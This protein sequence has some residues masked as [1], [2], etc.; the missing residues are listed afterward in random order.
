[1]K[2]ETQN[3]FHHCVNT[4]FCVEHRTSSI[5]ISI[6]LGTLI[7]YLS[8]QESDNLFSKLKLQLI[9]T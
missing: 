2:Y 6:S 7:R 1:M 8:K 4:I 5:L 3:D 9:S